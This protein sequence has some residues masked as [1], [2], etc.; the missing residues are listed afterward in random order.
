[1]KLIGNKIL[2]ELI[3]DDNTTKSGIILQGDQNLNSRQAKV[4]IVGPNVKH[5]KV[6]DVL[7]YQKYAKDF[8]DLNDKKCV[9]L[10]EDEDVLFK[11]GS[12]PINA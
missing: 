1:M 11:V 5:F 9:F 12:D 4:I 2:A 6:G 8:M 7:Q 3:E 10:K